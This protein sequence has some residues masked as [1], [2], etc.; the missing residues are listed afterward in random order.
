MKTVNVATLKNELSHWLREVAAGE[1]VVVVS[2]Q[3]AVAK[4]VP[5]PKTAQDLKIHL[6]RSK[7][8]QWNKIKGVQPLK[9]VDPVVLLLEDRQRR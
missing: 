6:P 3:H 9:P 7:T 5:L 4:L 1:E 2:H 8:P